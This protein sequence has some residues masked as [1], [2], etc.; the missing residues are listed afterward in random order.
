MLPALYTIAT[1]A[2]QVLLRNDLTRSCAAGM[3]HMSHSYFFRWSDMLTNAH[4]QRSHY[5]KQASAIL[6]HTTVPTHTQ[7]QLPA[8]S[9]QE[10]LKAAQAACT[11]ERRVCCQSQPKPEHQPQLTALPIANSFD[12]DICFWR[13]LPA[14][15][16]TCGMRGRDVVSVQAFDC[17]LYRSTYCC[18]G[19]LPAWH[20]CQQT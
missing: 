9:A 20:V 1:V 12:D 8:Q 19:S 13:M 17:L 5:T 15:P 11:C 2:T 7:T 14:C 3:M 16:D 6:G 4:G 10:I 18:F